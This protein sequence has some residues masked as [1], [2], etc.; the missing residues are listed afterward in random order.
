MN[1][2]QHWLVRVAR[3]AGLDG[4]AALSVAPTAPIETAWETVCRTCGIDEEQL[5]ER[6]A[7]H[8][9]LEPAQELCAQPAAL[10]LLPAEWAQRHNV[11][12]LRQD[13]DRIVVATADPANL[14]LE[15]EIRF[16]TGR[17]PIFRVAGPSRLAQEVVNHYSPATAA[18]S[19]LAS[20]SASAEFEVRAEKLDPEDLEDVNASPI[21]QLTQAILAEG[22]QQG[23]SDIH[24][25]TTRAGGIVRYR[26][27]GVLVTAM[28]L[29][30]PIVGRVIARIKVIG[31]LDLADRRR[32]Q[33]GRARIDV[34]GK[35]YDL[36][37][38][39]VPTRG[40]EKAVIRIL[41]ASKV[42]D[43]AALGLLERERAVF[44]RLMQYRDG[45]VLVTGPTGS[46][47]TTTL[48]ALLREVATEEVNVMTVED[49]VE[50]ELRGITQIQVEPAQGV[51]FASALRAILRQDPDVVLVGEIRDRETAEI[52]VQASMTG[53]LVLATLHTNDAVGVVR[54]LGDL[55]LDRASI[56]ETLRGA[57]A[58]RLLRRVCPHCAARCEPESLG[59][60]L[61]QLAD[62]YGVCPELVATGCRH[63]HDK[64]YRGRL[65]VMEFFLVDPAIQEAISAGTTYTELCRLAL[66][67]G[68]TTLLDAGLERV[69]RGDTTLEEVHRVLGAEAEGN[70]RFELPPRT[71]AAERSD[72]AGGGAATDLP[73]P[74]AEPRQS[75]AAA[76]PPH[77]PEGTGGPSGPVRVL[78][79]DDQAVDRRM[80]AMMLRQA[81]FEVLEAPSGRAA[82]ELLLAHPDVAM[83][84]TD[85]QMPDGDGRQLLHWLRQ[86]PRLAR[87]PVL[88]QTGT[89]EPA[90]EAQLMEEGADDY[91][92]K[93]LQPARFI[94]RVRATLRRAGIDTGGF[95]SA[96]DTLR[97]AG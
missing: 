57:V 53:H 91:V 46:G 62:R 80:A 67:R 6:V 85:L 64:G 43:L 87:M 77:R 51:T 34:A 15:E 45:I 33:D 82:A 86:V 39:T 44:D 19:L 95:P 4:S 60:E 10:K 29:P 37:V 35:H 3:E 89:P 69:R 24:I 94:A 88:V 28:Q 20:V 66:A 92:R 40:Y 36:R 96:G 38:S 75:P 26:I 41:D 14:L 1:A 8:Y 65:A 23:A 17:Q 27:D 5:A 50:Y 84:V 48:Y 31:D 68:M 47:K 81:G 83:L 18:E 61:R 78:L 11:L 55:G 32:P 73:A 2:Q 42:P 72:A 63:C 30:L 70:E 74:T 22:V 12:P 21:I 90:L 59:P 7:R 56:A 97:R 54:R 25:E 9:G 58:Q 79:A 93:P 52:A 13:D 16:T 49:P 71:A 76:A